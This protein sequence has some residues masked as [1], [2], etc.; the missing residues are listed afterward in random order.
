MVF[1]GFMRRKELTWPCLPDR[2][3]FVLP[4]FFEETAA[5]TTFAAGCVLLEWFLDLFSFLTA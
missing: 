5:A 4:D 1:F 3:A 2:T